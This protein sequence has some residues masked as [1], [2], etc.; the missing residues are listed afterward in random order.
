MTS[1]A[2]RAVS[3]SISDSR[4][5]AASR[6]PDPGQRTRRDSFTVGESALLVPLNLA[7]EDAVLAARC[8]WRVADRLEAWDDV[9]GILGALGLGGDR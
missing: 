9:P 5:A 2:S 1:Q 6:V 8:V 3:D 4:F 7:P